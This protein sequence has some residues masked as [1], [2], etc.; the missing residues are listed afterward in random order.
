MDPH[1][2]HTRAEPR[3]HRHVSSSPSSKPH[4]QDLWIFAY[5]EMQSMADGVRQALDLAD[6]NEEGPLVVARRGDI[7]WGRFPDSFPNLFI[8]KPHQTVRGKHLVFFASFFHPESMFAQLSGTMERVDEE[9]QIATAMS[10]ARLLSSIPPLGEGPAKVLI[11]DIHALG[12]RFYFGDNIIP[13]FETAIPLIID[14]IKT[15]HRDENVAIAFPDEGAIKRFG[16][17]FHEFDTILCS[18][19]RGEGN[20]RIVTVKEGDAAGR[21]VFIIDD[22]VQ[23]GGTLIECKNALIKQGAKDVSAYVTHAIF[24]GDSWKRFTDPTDEKPFKNFYITDSCPS[25]AATL[26]DTK[27]FAVLPLAE[28]ISAFLR[29][30]A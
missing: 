11:Y 7:K 15:A 1:K 14:K 5:P 30:I 8:D 26:Q 23:T 3:T 12:E 6:D 9:G 20:K 25:V 24:P 29:E 27:P 21:H 13:M 28:P 18:K 17:Q 4:G 16:G 10:L 2:H 22:L 19:V